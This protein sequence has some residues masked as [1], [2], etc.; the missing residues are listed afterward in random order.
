MTDF[1]AWSYSRLKAFETCPRQYYHMRLA[2]TYEEP[3][4][5]E[6]RYGT[7][8]HTAAE[9]YVLH[10]TEPEERFRYATAV[11]DRVRAMPGDHYCEY[12]M[13]LDINLSPC[14]MDDPSVWWKGI[15]DVLVINGEEARILDWKTGKSAERADTGQL[16]LMAMG[17][18]KHFPQVKRVKAGLVYVVCNAFI[19]D[20]YTVDQESELW[21][22][23]LQ[24]YRQYRAAHK[25]D[26]FNPKPSGLCKR[27]CAVVCCEHNG[28]R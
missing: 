28:R 10:G 16:E 26:V 13:G 25:H 23:W 6:Q 20:N 24:K 9:N 11:L 8:F 1:P 3:E 5:Y 14:K 21:Q 19:K 4:T 27:W 12:E 2:R 15:A 18:F 22:K 7:D 17:V